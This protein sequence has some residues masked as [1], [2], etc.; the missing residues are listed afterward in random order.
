VITNGIPGTGML[1]FKFDT[2]ELTG[3]VA[4][5]RNMNSF[6]RGSVKLGD[7]ARGRIA[8]EGRGGCLRC[9]RVGSTPRGLL[10]AHPIDRAAMGE[11][12]EPSRERPSSRPAR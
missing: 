10:T 8:F 9:H 7:A 6:E 3:I 4:Y 1:A 11:H 12:P 5:L 2:A